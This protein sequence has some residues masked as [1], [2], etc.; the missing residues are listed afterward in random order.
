[1]KPLIGLVASDGLA[2]ATEEQALRSLY[3]DEVPVT[4]YDGRSLT[5]VWPVAMAPGRAA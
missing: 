2:L 1:M 5:A 3:R 4:N